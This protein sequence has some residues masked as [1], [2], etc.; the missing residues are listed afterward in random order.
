[1]TQRMARIK[2][3]SMDL[4]TTEDGN[5]VGG[6]LKLR[7]HPDGTT[8]MKRIEPRNSKVFKLDEDKLVGLDIPMPEGKSSDLYDIDLVFEKDSVVACGTDKEWRGKA[9]VV[10]D[11]KP[12]WVVDEAGKSLMGRMIGL[13][14]TAGKTLLC[15]LSEEK[16][17]AVTEVF[18]ISGGI[19]KRLD[20]NVKIRGHLEPVDG[21]SDSP[22]LVNNYRDP[23]S[24]KA[25][26]ELCVLTDKGI[27]PLKLPNDD[28]AHTLE[29][30]WSR[31]YG[32]SLLTG[33]LDNG[34]LKVGVVDGQVLR[35]L[36]LPGYSTDTLIFTENQSLKGK[37]LVAF[38]VSRRSNHEAIRVAGLIEDATLVPL[39]DGH[40][41]LFQITAVAGDSIYGLVGD[42][43]RMT[44]LCRLTR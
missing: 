18:Q 15:W 36:K 34:R 11:G 4:I 19:A 31:R 8:T 29:K 41:R 38:E 27:Q 7:S 25:I 37:A 40:G 9:W 30:S 12:E 5:P 43:T 21:H 2:D 26:Y 17:K 24:R 10:R 16:N 3:G 6:Q 20:W 44:G 1:M 28:P 42:S 35:P 13:F 39:K 22:L 32:S 14:H 23:D 33:F